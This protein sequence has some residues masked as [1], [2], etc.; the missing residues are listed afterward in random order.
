MGMTC[1]L[2][3]NFK[4]HS[5][6]PVMCAITDIGWNNGF[7]LFEYTVWIFEVGTGYFLVIVLIQLLR[8]V[9]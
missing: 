7:G 5:F 1:E 8:I 2:W 9:E 3:I 6:F 4:Q